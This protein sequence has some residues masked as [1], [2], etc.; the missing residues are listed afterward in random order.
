MFQQHTARGGF[1]PYEF[2]RSAQSKERYDQLHKLIAKVPP[3]AKITS[4]E[5]IVPQVS[6]RPDSYTLRIGVFDAEYLLFQQ[7]ARDDERRFARQALETE[8][9][10]VVATN[11]PFVLAQRGHSSDQNQAVLRHLR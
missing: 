9:F 6:N 8:G 4:S 10:G 3:R 7:P 5:N 11:G 2:G 1:G